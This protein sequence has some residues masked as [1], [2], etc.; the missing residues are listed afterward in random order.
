[1]TMHKEHLKK[2]CDAKTLEERPI[3][4]E[5]PEEL[6]RRKRGTQHHTEVITKRRTPGVD[7][8]KFKVC[9]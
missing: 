5:E 2:Q 8:T 3:E 9:I 4:K 7:D 1:M 6:E